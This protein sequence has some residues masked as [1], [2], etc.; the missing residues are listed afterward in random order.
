MRGPITAEED[1]I[2]LNGG[3]PTTKTLLANPKSLSYDDYLEINL[4]MKIDKMMATANSNEDVHDKMNGVF[5]QFAPALSGLDAG[6]SDPDSITFHGLVIMIMSHDSHNDLNQNEQTYFATY[7]HFPQP[8][9]V[10][11]EYISVLFD[12]R[13]QLTR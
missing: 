1:S 2:L 11:R 6:F 5:I 7:R 10:K 13:G 4:K 9:V 12:K 8:T 3:L